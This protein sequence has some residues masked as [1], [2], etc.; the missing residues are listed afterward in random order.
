MS[1]PITQAKR[2]AAAQRRQAKAQADPE[3]HEHTL[4]RM[5]AYSAKRRKRTQHA[6]AK[7]FALLGAK[8]KAR[9][10]AKQEPTQ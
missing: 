10:R 1:K 3:A 9:Q 4:A 8:P 5:R 6:I 7:L 2:L